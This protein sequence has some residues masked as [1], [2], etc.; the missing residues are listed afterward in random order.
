M[1]QA[2][3]EESGEKAYEVS[4]LAETEEKIEDIK[5]LVGQHGAVLAREFPQKKINLAYPI[6]HATQAIFAAWSVTASPEKIKLLEKDLQG[7]KN[8]MRSLIITLPIE[9]NE[10]RVEEKKPVPARRAGF[11]RR[12]PRAEKAKPL[13]NEAIEKKI[14]EILK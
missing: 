9:K 10:D 6:K 7:N 1:E 2:L 4:F 3:R 14:E 12:E 8:V 5:R 11:L 13:S